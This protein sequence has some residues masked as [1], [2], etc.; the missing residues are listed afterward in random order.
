VFRATRRHRRFFLAGANHGVNG[1]DREHGAPVALTGS[2]TPFAASLQSIP[3]PA[4]DHSHLTQIRRF[5]PGS[6]QTIVAWADAIR[7]RAG[8]DLASAG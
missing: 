6:E 5:I 8:Y 4:L 7:R 3:L 2:L 1:K